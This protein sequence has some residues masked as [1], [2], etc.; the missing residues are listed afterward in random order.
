MGGY[1]GGKE[2]THVSGDD[3]SARDTRPEAGERKRVMKRGSRETRASARGGGG[4][5]HGGKY[6]REREREDRGSG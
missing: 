5:G 1:G 2:I 3:L 4:G 6:K